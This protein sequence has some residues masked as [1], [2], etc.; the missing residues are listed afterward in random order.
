M[1]ENKEF[2]RFMEIM[3]TLRGEGGCPWDREQTHE[4]LRWSAVE[5]AY[6]LTE[7]ID[8]KDN[9]NMCEELGDILLQV[10]LHS[11]IAEEKHAFTMEDV[12]RGI[13]DK[14][15]F[16]HP[17][18]FKTKEKGLTS[19]EV[20]DSW[21]Q[22]KAKEKKEE[23][24]GAGLERVAK[25]LP[26]NVRAEKIQKKAAKALGSKVDKFEAIR[27]TRNVLDE[28]EKNMKGEGKPQTVEQFE[29]L[30]FSVINI[31]RSLGLSAE[32]SLTNATNKFINRFVSA[33]R[34]ALENGKG[35]AQ[36]S[37]NERD[38]LWTSNT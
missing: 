19:D 23:T 11:L 21:E 18:V 7:A 5:E 22:I 4:S 8:N 12:L 38:A 15:I 9:A 26:A 24:V 25:A 20:L 29:K 37:P 6:E 28:L 35:L 10:C 30:M 16:R 14:M 2:E 1:D 34:E 33:E 32:I 36:M 3:R 31:S 27:Q 17:H 13:T